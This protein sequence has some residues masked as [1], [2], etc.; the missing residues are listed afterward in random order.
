MI[1][2]EKEFTGIGEVKNTN[3]K[4]LKESDKG[5]LYELTDLEDNSKRYEVFERKEQKDSEVVLN[6]ISIHYNAKIR[7]PRS[8]DFGI[9]A[10][11]Y[12]IYSQAEKKFNELQ[13][14]KTN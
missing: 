4:Q 8:K 1:Q 6:D 5:F 7:Y 11:C 10:W 13:L 9:W 12:S 3:F 2:L 14:Q